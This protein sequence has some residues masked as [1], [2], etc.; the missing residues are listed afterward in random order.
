MVGE[1]RLREEGLL[2]SVGWL[3]RGGRVAQA[4]VGAPDK[5]SFVWDQV[6]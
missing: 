5:R 6:F 3:G 1:E 4:I 2:V